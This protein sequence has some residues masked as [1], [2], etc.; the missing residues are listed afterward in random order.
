ML[1]MGNANTRINYVFKAL[2]V[3]RL[4]NSNASINMIK[5]I[6]LKSIR[7]LLNGLNRK[8]ISIIKFSPKSIILFY[9]IKISKCKLIFNL[10]IYLVHGRMKYYKK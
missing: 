2:I 4:G 5:N 9:T 10:L 1:N 6:I 8:I 3:Q 7:C